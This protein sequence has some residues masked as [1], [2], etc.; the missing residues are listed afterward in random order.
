MVPRTSPG[1]LKVTVTHM[2]KSHHPHG[3]SHLREEAKGASCVSRGVFAREL[4]Q[5][6]EHQKPKNHLTP[7]FKASP[8]ARIWQLSLVM[9]TELNPHPEEHSSALTHWKKAAVSS[10]AFV[11]QDLGEEEPGA[12]SMLAKGQRREG[13]RSRGAQEHRGA[14]STG[15]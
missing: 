13:R 3:D 4:N 5:L 7:H 8:G 2:W 15:L 6:Q 1:S 9:S 12:C 10:E 11:I 14:A